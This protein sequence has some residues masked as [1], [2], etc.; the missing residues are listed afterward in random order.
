M[1]DEVLPE[2]FE[3]QS[4][5]K[6]EQILAEVLTRNLGNISLA[7]LQT[8]LSKHPELRKLPE[9]YMVPLAVMEAEQYAF[10]AI[11]R[12][13]GLYAPLNVHFRAFE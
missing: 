7:E 10:D 4:V 2:L 6:T 8:A 5:L 12:E 11:E 3:Q 13:R 9:N 1:I